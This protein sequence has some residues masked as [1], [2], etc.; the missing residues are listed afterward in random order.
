[1][2]N[3]GFRLKPGLKPGVAT[4]ATQIEGGDR[5]NSWYDWYLKGKI[6]DNS[7]PKRANRHYDLFREDTELLKE[8]GIEHY[9]FGVEWS[10]IEP[11]NGVFDEEVL[12]HYRE[13]I[14][15]LKQYGI[16]PLLT[17]HH[18]TN[19]M[20]FEDLDAFENPENIPLFLRYVEKVISSLGDLVNEYITINEPNVYAVGGYFFGIWPPGKKSI[21]S[22][23]KVYQNLSCCH[24]QSYRLI[25]SL[26][27]KTGYNDT[28]VGFAHHMRIFEAKN[29]KNPVHVLYA[30]VMDRL[31]QESICKAFMTGDFDFPLKRPKDIVKGKYYDFIGLNYYTRSTI[32]RFEDGVKENVPVNDLGWEIYPQ[33]IVVCAKRLYEQ[34]PSPIYITENGTCD[35][36]D[37]FRC[38]YIYEH[39]KAL[40][41]SDLPVERYYHWCF[42]DNFE[43]LEGES[44]RFG[45]VHVDY[46]TQKRTLKKS[47]LFYSQLIAQEGISEETALEC[48]SEE[49]KTSNKETIRTGDWT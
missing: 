35:N 16:Q 39:L 22:V 36:E 24:I 45:L 49:Y 15:L 38:R 44:A 12:S 33:G 26:R 14:S 27:E 32:S 17:L 13:E 43:W 40:S 2:N 7:N 25:H 4:S 30:N 1:M 34:Y 18:F 5:N 28:K 9:R 11:D 29:P 21:R 48:L 37:S 3:N 31:F 42:L 20:W 19:P 8:I 47:G 46:E 23:L 41:E 6:K 10:R